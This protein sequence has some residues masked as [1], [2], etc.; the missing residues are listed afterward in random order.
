MLVNLLRELIPNQKCLLYRTCILLII[1]Y[2]FPLQY[3]N[4]ASLAY[5]LSIEFSPGDR[6]IDIFP[7]YFLFYSLDHKNE[8]SRKAHICK[9]DKLIFPV[10]ADSKTAIVVSDTSIKN[11]VAILI[12]YIHIYNNSVIKTIY[13]T[14]NITFTEVKLFAIRYSIN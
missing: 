3:Y 7:S 4:K 13:H 1:P 11:Q 12:A 6:L 14:I 2:G 10:P 5:P 8:K 9:L